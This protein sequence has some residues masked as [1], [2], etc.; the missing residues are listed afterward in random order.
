[1]FVVFEASLQM[2]CLLVDLGSILLVCTARLCKYKSYDDILLIHCDLKC[3][4]LRGGMVAVT[5]CK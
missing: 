1:M 3:V 2:P 5:S 4:H